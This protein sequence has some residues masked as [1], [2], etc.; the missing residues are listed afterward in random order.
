MVCFCPLASRFRKTIHSV[1]DISHEK[2]PFQFFHFSVCRTRV[3]RRAQSNDRLLLRKHGRNTPIFLYPIRS[4]RLGSGAGVQRVTH[5]WTYGGQSAFWHRKQPGRLHANR[6][7]RQVHRGQSESA[8]HDKQSN[9]IIPRTRY[10]LS[11]RPTPVNTFMKYTTYK[12]LVARGK[13]EK[14]AGLRF[15]NLLAYLL[16]NW[17]NGYRTTETTHFT[18]N[19]GRLRNR[20]FFIRFSISGDIFIH[21]CCMFRFDW[22]SISFHCASLHIPLLLIEN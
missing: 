5:K 7:T 2:V 13:R 15:S 19:A 4:N 10:H 12:L 6:T 21:Y 8:S 18:R 1:R 20:C 11:G 16:L 3:C 22:F 9:S 17:V 14:T